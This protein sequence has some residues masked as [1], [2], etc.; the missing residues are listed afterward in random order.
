MNDFTVNPSNLRDGAS[1]VTAGAEA[2]VS[3]SGRPQPANPD[4]YGQI[5]SGSVGL[6]E[7]F[8]TDAFKEFLRSCGVLSDSIS[9]RLTKSADGY[10][11][12]EATNAEESNKI[13]SS[14]N[15]LFD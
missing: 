13:T 9:E 14:I 15:D 2:F 11:E 4:D 1:K 10:T 12:T 3:S 7:P 6:A 5:V 8:T